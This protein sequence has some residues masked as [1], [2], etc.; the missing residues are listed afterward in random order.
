MDGA[1]L[2][3]NPVCDRTKC[4]REC[5]ELIN[6]SSEWREDSKNNE[7]S[8]VTVTAPGQEPTHWVR[9]HLVLLSSTQPRPLPF[10]PPDLHLPRLHRSLHRLLGP[11]WLESWCYGGHGPGG[12]SEITMKAEMEIVSITINWFN[13][14]CQSLLS[15]TNFWG[16]WHY[17]AQ[18]LSSLQSLLATDTFYIL[19]PRNKF[20][21]FIVSLHTR[22]PVAK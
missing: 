18:F 15:Q 14:L 12:E 3:I 7:A 10:H 21:V 4:E 9:A 22:F 16:P 5:L 19:I 8:S 2:T 6:T 20:G 13:G 11:P 17:R 1:W